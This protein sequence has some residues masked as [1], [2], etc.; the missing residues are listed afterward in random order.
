M[1]KPMII[2]K[3]MNSDIEMQTLYADIESILYQRKTITEI[4]NV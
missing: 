1:I 2:F 3:E 4:E